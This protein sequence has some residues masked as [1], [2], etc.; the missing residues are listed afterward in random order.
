MEFMSYE[1]VARVCTTASLLL[2]IAI[3]LFMLVYVFGFA[4]REKLDAAQKEALDLESDKK[5]RGN[6]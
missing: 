4:S 6:S 3:F 2:F 1:A 5:L